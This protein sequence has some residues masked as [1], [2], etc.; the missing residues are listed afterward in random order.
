[1]T[2]EELERW[3]EYSRAAHARSKENP[4]QC[5][6]CWRPAMPRRKLCARCKTRKWRLANPDK[7]G[8][9][10]SEYR[11]R[12]RREVVEL[13]GGMCDCCGEAETLFLTLDHA[14]D[15]GA[16]SRR[17]GLSNAGLLADAVARYGDG[18]YRLLCW[19][20]NSGRQLNN[21]ICPHVYPGTT[22]GTMDQREK[23]T[24]ELIASALEHEAEAQELFEDDG[25]GDRLAAG[26]RRVA[27]QIR[28]GMLPG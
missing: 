14:E 27:T 22:G 20:C 4:K 7:A 28:A 13:Y 6:E 16:A 17:S 3:R 1:M 24:V 26:F 5:A 19:N 25:L 8:S 9:Y 18:Y 21:G 12:R 10:A 2:P 11:Q 15:D 23:E